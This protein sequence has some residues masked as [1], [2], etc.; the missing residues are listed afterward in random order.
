MWESQPL[1][2]FLA[3]NFATFVSPWI[4][5]KEALA[6]FLGPVPARAPNEPKLLDYLFDADDQAFGALNTSLQTFLLTESMRASGKPAVRV[7]AANTRDLY[8]TFAQMVAHHTSGGCPLRPGDLFG[9]GTISGPQRDGYGSL[10]ELTDGGGA[11]IDL[12]DGEVRAFL[13]DGDEVIFRAR[14]ERDGF[15]AIGFGECRG[16]IVSELR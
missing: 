6:P 4:V 10:I 2:P 14:C 1:G 16:R 5:T 3:K 7:S 9:S 12:G 13:E 11:P 15:V 8:W